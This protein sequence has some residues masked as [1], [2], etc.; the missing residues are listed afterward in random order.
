MKGK[1]RV[2]NFS[3][4][5]VREVLDYN[6]ATGV[7]VWKVNIAKNVKVG[8]V[9][10]GQ[11]K[12]NGYSYIRLDGEEVTVGRLAWFYV[13]GE[14]PERRVQF[15][16][17]DINDA[18]FENLSLSTAPSG[19][20][21]FKSREGK[22]AYLRAYRKAN[23]LIEKGRALR[24]SFGLSLAQYTEMAVAQD[25]KCAICEKPEVEK[26]GGKVKALAVD[27]N[28]TT[29]R[30]RGL[31]CTSCNKAIG[32]LN[33][34]RDRFLSAVRYLDRH[35]GEGQNVVTLGAVKGS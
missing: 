31:L 11:G 12:G 4:E 18:R 23:P 17:R 2:A 14:W 34:D 16:N 32:L 29:G 3:H 35:S 21:D 10:G 7:F 6:P 8:T 27:H 26:R 33:E 15:K 9:A 20:F 5:R 25:G 13:T 30:V 28:H 24:E 22:A 1:S 19:D